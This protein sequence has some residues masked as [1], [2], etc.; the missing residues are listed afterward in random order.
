MNDIKS[1]NLKKL[2]DELL[3]LLHSL[4]ASFDHLH[5]NIFKIRDRIIYKTYDH[6][7]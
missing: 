7:K 1:N 2:A 5:E 6:S 4:T 3:G